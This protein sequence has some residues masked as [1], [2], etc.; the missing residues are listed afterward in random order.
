MDTATDNGAVE[1]TDVDSAAAEI[2]RRREVRAEPEPL[3]NESEAEETEAEASE[4]DDDKAEVSEANDDPEVEEDAEEDAPTETEASSFKTIT[5]LAE[6]VDMPIDEF[7]AQIKLTTKVNGE[8]S[9]V[10]LSDLQK[11]YQTEAD[12]TRK[13][14]DL[15][16][17]RKTLEQHHTN[18]RNELQAEMQ[19]AGVTLKLAQ[20][21]LSNDFN[22]IDW[23]G[24]QASDPTQFMLQR[25]QFGE[26]QAQINQQ[27]ESATQQAQAFQ[28]KQTQDAEQAQQTYLQ[29][30]SESLNKAIPTWSD[31]KVRNA[32]TAKLTEYLGK[33]GFNT[34]EI[35]KITDHRIILLARQAMAAGKEV[36]AIDIAKKKV[37]KAPKLVKG[38]ARQNVNQKQ[39]SI[40]ALTQ[41]AKQSGSV[42]DVAQMLLAR[43]S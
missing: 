21:Q 39:K 2:Q 43:R 29:K 15:A 40:A 17:Q 28:D 20:N 35:S 32:E 7:M 4:I 25:Q 33:S 31:D 14:M 6:A 30:E 27:I 36:T 8:E 38:N 9:E 42:D 10:T 37:K 3:S 26:R 23:N 1:V 18:A 19:K 34:D 41:K 13:S 5:E 11:G 22:S 12:N 24:L 16:E